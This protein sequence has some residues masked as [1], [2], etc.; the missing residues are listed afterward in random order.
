LR[1]RRA[2][3]GPLLKDVRKLVGK[4]ARTTLGMRQVLV[5][6]EHDVVPTVKAS[7]PIS[8]AA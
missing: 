3:Q 4:Q 7:A 2:C 1:L 8:A 5:G 6:R